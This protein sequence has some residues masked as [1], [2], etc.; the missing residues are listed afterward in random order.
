MN[1]IYKKQ[2]LW[3]LICTSQDISYIWYNSNESD[4]VHPQLFAGFVVITDKKKDLLFCQQLKDMKMRV[5]S[6][7]SGT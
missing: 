1:M 7:S 3:M 2:E 6:N 5:E 4:H